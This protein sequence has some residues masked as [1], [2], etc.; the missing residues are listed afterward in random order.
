MKTFPSVLIIQHKMLFK[1][2]SLVL[3]KAN[4]GPLYCGLEMRNQNCSGAVDF[5]TNFRQLSGKHTKPGNQSNAE[6]SVVRFSK[7]QPFLKVPSVILLH[8]QLKIISV[9]CKLLH[10]FI[11]GKDCRQ[12]FDKKFYLGVYFEIEFKI[13]H[14]ACFGALFLNWIICLICLNKQRME[15]VKTVWILK[16]FY[17]LSN[18]KCYQ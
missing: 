5:F 17:G 9:S 18:L 8:L 6:I 7:W 15:Q 10:I 14:F 13:L 11:V 1:H 2:F 3:E 4:T 16:I 12:D